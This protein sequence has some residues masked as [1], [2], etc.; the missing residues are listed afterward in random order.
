MY[1]KKLN[2]FNN[3]I[4]DLPKKPKSSLVFYVSERL[5]TFDVKNNNLN[6]DEYIELILKEWFTNKTEK[7]KEVFTELA[8][9][10][11]LRFERE[12]LEFETFGYYY[13]N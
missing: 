2:K 8:K 4:F 12:I 6:V 11:K 13:I 7:D 3:K 1:N 5:K 10:D 9:K